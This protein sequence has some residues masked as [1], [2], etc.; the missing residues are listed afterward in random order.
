TTCTATRPFCTARPHGGTAASPGRLGRMAST[1]TGG[2]GRRRMRGQRARVLAPPGALAGRPLDRGAPRRQGGGGVGGPCRRRGWVGRLVATGTAR[3]RLR[4][5][6]PA[7]IDNRTQ[8]EAFE[9]PAGDGVVKCDFD[10]GVFSSDDLHPFGQAVPTFLS[11]LK[12]LLV[13][14][15]GRRL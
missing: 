8:L 12:C 14:S 11:L 3:R 10:V 13:T 4:V 15:N 6:A 7:V 1:A 5:E 2:G 9:E